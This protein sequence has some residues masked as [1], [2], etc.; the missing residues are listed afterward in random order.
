MGDPYKAVRELHSE[1]QRLS[2][3]KEGLIE[4]FKMM[5]DVE[6]EQ[7]NILDKHAAPFLDMAQEIAQKLAAANHTIHE[8]R[9][10]LQGVK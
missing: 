10:A 3:S 9:S 5:L 4:R 2:I 8:V 7:V 1:A 6:Q